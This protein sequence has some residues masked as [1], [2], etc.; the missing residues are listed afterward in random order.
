MIEFYVP[1]AAPQHKATEQLPD[2]DFDMV[3]AVGSDVPFHEQH[4]QQLHSAL[5]HLLH[6][7]A[8]GAGYCQSERLPSFITNSLGQLPIL[9]EDGTPL[10]KN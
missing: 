10:I 6:Q 4:H 1:P 9:T 7:T 5:Y 2:Q 8:P 3:P